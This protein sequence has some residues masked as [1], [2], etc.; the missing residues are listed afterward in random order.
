MSIDHNHFSPFVNIT[1]YLK[2]IDIVKAREVGVEVSHIIVIPGMHNEIGKVLASN[3]ELWLKNES[4][5]VK[6]TKSDVKTEKYHGERFRK[7][8]DTYYFSKFK[9]TCNSSDGQ[10]TRMDFDSLSK[11]ELLAYSQSNTI[12]ADNKTPSLLQIAFGV[13]RKYPSLNISIYKRR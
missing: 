5:L 8:T 1:N 12:V 7:Y 11:N 13:L 9:L 6:H 2:S 4:D 3:I 10:T